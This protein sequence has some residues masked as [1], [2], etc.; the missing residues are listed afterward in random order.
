MLS[1]IY[2]NKS[3]LFNNPFINDQIRQNKS[4]LK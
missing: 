2:V 4:K 3:E 1:K